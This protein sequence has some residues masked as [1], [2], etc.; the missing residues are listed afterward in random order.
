MSL[1]RRRRGR[2]RPL[3]GV[4]RNTNRSRWVVK[5]D[6]SSL[7]TVVRKH[8]PS[9]SISIRIITRVV[10]PRTSP[11]IKQEK[12]RRIVDGSDNT[13]KYSRWHRPSILFSSSINWGKRSPH[14]L[15]FAVR[16]RRENNLLSRERGTR[17]SE[18]APRPSSSRLAST[19]ICVRT[20]TSRA[21]VTRTSAHASTLP[22]SD[23]CVAPLASSSSS[24][25]SPCR[26]DGK[27][28]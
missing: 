22:L 9:I 13:G 24:R 17:A 2:T 7:I 5:P 23:I 15:R 28:V 19:S 26:S 14:L 11:R 10:A 27:V 6:V 18:R 21:S 3:R 1:R 20:A 12:E 16:R 8:G 25:H 4:T